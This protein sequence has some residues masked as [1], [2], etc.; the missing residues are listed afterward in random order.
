MKNNKSFEKQMSNDQTLSINQKLE[1]I[2]SLIEDAEREAEKTGTT[3]VFLDF[4][5]TVCR[6]FLVNLPKKKTVS[7][8]RI[9]DHIEE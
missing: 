3:G 4:Y 9:A 7:E 6:G 2:M 1:A 8:P 5:E